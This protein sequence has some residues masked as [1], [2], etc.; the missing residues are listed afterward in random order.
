M[1]NKSTKLKRL[2]A[3]KNTTLEALATAL[4]MDRSTLYRK[5][6]GGLSSLTIGDAEK[7][8]KFLAL[9]EEEIRFLFRGQ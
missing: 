6:K 2:I 7:I 5:M 3:K 9:S 8:I 1:E 4:G